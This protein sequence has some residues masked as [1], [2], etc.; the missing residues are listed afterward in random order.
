M[1]ACAIVY[2]TKAVEA[3]EELYGAYGTIYWRGH[4]IDNQDELTGAE[5]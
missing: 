4:D 5:T 3:G 1:Q 2:T